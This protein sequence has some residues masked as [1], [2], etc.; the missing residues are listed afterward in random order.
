M[1]RKVLDTEVDEREHDLRPCVVQQ[2]LIHQI[3]SLVIIQKIK[4]EHAILQEYRTTREQYFY[5]RLKTE[6]NP[7]D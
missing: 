4:L 6:R 2:N 5:F 3:D 7:C 1:L